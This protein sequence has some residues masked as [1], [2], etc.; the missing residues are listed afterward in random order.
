MRNTDEQLRQIAPRAEKRKRTS[1]RTA[2]PEA[3]MVCASLVLIVTAALS[4]PNLSGSAAVSQTSQYGSL[5]LIRPF[6]G[7]VIIGVLAFLLGVCITLLCFRLQR[8]RNGE[9]K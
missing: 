8:D 4:M 9:Q 3:L 2:L 6:L 5:I 7:Y 1:R